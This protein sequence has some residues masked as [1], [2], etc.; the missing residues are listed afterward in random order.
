ML[1]LAS[2]QRKGFTL[3]ELL[4]VIA[5]IAI[6]AAILFPVLSK[7][8][9]AAKQSSCESNLKQLGTAM[10][11]YLASWDDMFPTNRGRM[12]SGMP[13][14]Q[15]V[16]E[17]VMLTPYEFIVDGIPAGTS[18]MPPEWDNLPDEDKF[19]EPMKFFY[20]VNWVEA[21]MNNMESVSA[22]DDPKSAWRCSTASEVATKL[23]EKQYFWPPGKN[24]PQETLAAVSYTMNFYLAEQPSSVISVPDRTMLVREFDGRAC[25]ALRPFTPDTEYYGMA[26]PGLVENSPYAPFLLSGMNTQ[27]DPHASQ[28]GGEFAINGK[29]HGAGSLVLFADSHVAHYAERTFT[30]GNVVQLDNGSYWLNEGGEDKIAITP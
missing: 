27:V 23:I 8:R 24:Q 4:V 28:S 22:W 10:K 19:G 9:E 15:W 26:L 12:P 1:K 7:A 18:P 14:N 3:I 21:L 17:E 20:G 16:C 11:Q 13:N 2:K 25:A 6:L 29:L 5:I 30:S